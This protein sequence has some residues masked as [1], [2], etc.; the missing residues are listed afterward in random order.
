MRDNK[1]VNE[2]GDPI[3]WYHGTAR[4]IESFKPKQADAVFLSPKADFADAFAETSQE[5]MQQNYRDILT[6]DQINQAKERAIKKVMSDRMIKRS[7][8]EQ[9]AN[10]I[11]TGVLGGE[12]ADAFFA[13]IRNE[14]PTGPNV[15]P[16]SARATNPFDYQDPQQIIDLIYTLKDR[17]GT[18]EVEITPVGSKTQTI[19]DDD[20]EMALRSGIWN[21]IESPEVQ[22]ALRVDLGH[23][24]DP[25]AVAVL[26]AKF[27]ALPLTIGQA[28]TQA[29]NQILRDIGAIDSALGA[30]SRIAQIIAKMAAV[31]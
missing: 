13:E 30:S 8:R 22:D 5:W 15:M 24:A 9:T 11:R 25:D 18:D 3:V 10:Q 1:L 16:L 7:L 14:M 20:L 28:F 19:S 23:D 31:D 29:R 6:E 2:Q 12:S 26:K 27:E 4:D 21:Y 17:Q